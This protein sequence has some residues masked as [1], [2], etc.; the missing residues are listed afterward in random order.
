M[1]T[2]TV[3]VLA[4]LGCFVFAGIQ[5]D[6]EAYDKIIQSLIVVNN[7]KI[8]IIEDR[9]DALEAYDPNDALYRLIPPA[10][11]SWI[12]I[13]GDNHKTRITHSLSEVRMVTG[14]LGRRVLALEKFHPD[15]N[16]PITDPNEG[17][18]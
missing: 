8:K 18:E 3:I 14:A 12:E 5:V 17:T 1:R 16:E 9:L 7:D 2:R 6:P 4:L 10:H 11:E 13:G 15:P